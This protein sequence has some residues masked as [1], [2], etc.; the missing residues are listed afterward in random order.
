M[1]RILAV[2]L[3]LAAAPALA[4]A[5][6][7]L[8]NL[9]TLNAQAER[10][11]PNDVLSAV[12]AV[13]AEGV[14]PAVLAD[15]VN[16]SMQKAIA[17]AQGYRAVRARS[18]SYQSFPVHDRNRIVRWRVRQEL[19]LES[20]DFAAAGELIGKLQGALVIASMALG[21]SPEARRQA[22][23][24]LTVEALAAFEERAR[25]VRDAMKS[26]GYRIKDLQVSGA[27]VSRPPMPFQARAAMAESSVA[28]PAIEA[29]TS[30][31]VITVSGT[32]QLQ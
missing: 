12:M 8:F 14:D 25:V 3:C 6:E 21:V 23:N 30:R 19:R 31:L 24:A 26:K 13:E 9:V 27:G 32:V 22:E 18:G 4:Q 16:R 28:A 29:G 7:S 15:S 2:L 11:A 1:K 10:E 17:V 20:S 5:P